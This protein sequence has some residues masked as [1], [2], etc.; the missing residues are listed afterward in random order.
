MSS[1][2]APASRSRE[3]IA[4]AIEGF[5]PADWVRLRRVARHY[6]RS[7]VIEADELLQEACTRAFESRTCPAHVDVVKFLA[8][9][10]RSIA[11]GEGEKSEPKLRV[12]LTPREGDQEDPI[13]QFPHPSPSAESEML[14]R[15]NNEKLRRDI[16][17]LF[18]D[19]TIA[20]DIVEG[21]MEDM[22][23]EELRELTGLDKTAYATKRKLIRR[24]IDQH[25]PNGW[26]S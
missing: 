11:N 10:M 7:L 26:K 9:A 12:V 15:E 2:Q 6:A 16:L 19:D 22:N 4:E 13:E 23:A 8:E 5:S 17:A 25:Y 1:K 21:T 3:E 14:Q 18:D 20:R 24:R